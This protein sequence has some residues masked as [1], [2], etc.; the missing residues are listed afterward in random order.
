MFTLPQYFQAVLGSDALG[1]GGRLLPLI[2]GL[3]VGTRIAGRVVERV[4]RRS[5]L[6]SGSALLSASI[7]AGAF[8]STGTAYGLSAVWIVGV[9]IGLG[10][11]LPTSMA[12]ATD[13]LDPAGAASGSALLQA[14]R[15]VAGTIGIAVL[16]TVLSAAYRGQLQLTGVPSSV[17]EA[18]RS[19]V[20]SGV[21]AAARSGS[22]Q[23]LDSVR[24][25][26][27]HGM[28]VVLLVCAVVAVG[29]A[30]LAYCYRDRPAAGVPV[31]RAAPVTVPVAGVVGAGGD[32]AQSLHEPVS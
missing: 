3:L 25:S 14:L 5:A 11:V 17:A 26:F 8:T 20:S 23:L 16:G 21:A 31:D 27:V 15:Q 18:A 4:G 9:G 29:A 10:F 19:S 24:S 32:A 2:G 22:G 6:I 12:I 13:A 7:G 30:V 28:D 1:T